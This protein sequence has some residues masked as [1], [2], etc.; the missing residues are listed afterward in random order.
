MSEATVVC[1]CRCACVWFHILGFRMVPLFCIST[2]E[3]L[4]VSDYS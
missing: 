1:V 2:G 3:S 4:D